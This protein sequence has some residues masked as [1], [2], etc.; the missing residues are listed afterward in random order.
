[1]R[2]SS[3]LAAQI[4][5]KAGE[6]VRPG[7]TTDQIDRLVHQLACDAGAYPSPLNYGKFPKSV[8]AGSG[9]IVNESTG[10]KKRE[11]LFTGF[12]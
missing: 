5:E 7:V 4:L 8:R 11:G 6:A 2:A 10:N 12:D 3:K 9:C 1:M